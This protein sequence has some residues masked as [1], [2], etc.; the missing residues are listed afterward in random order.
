MEFRLVS[1]TRCSVSTLRKR[2]TNP[3]SARSQGGGSQP[4]SPPQPCSGS[5]ARWGCQA[6]FSLGRP[7]LPLLRAAAEGLE[8][9]KARHGVGG[10]ERGGEYGAQQCGWGGVVIFPV[11]DGPTGLRTSSD[12][13]RVLRL[14]PAIPP[15][16]CPPPPPCA[17]ALPCSVPCPHPRSTLAACAGLSGPACRAMGAGPLLDEPGLWWLPASLSQNLPK[18]H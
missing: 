9:G 1:Q 6:S 13:T 14:L 18:C 4:P 15:V 11:A 3:S 16:L 5:W 17:M 10:P 2:R 12:L 8:G 7:L